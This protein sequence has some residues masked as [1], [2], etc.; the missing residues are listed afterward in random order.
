MDFSQQVM[1]GLNK[2]L[3]KQ[4]LAHEHAQQRL[5]VMIRAINLIPDQKKYHL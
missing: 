5:Q 3:A 1:Q 4:Q 2:H